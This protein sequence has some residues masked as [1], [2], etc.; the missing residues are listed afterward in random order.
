MI[1]SYDDLYQILQTAIDKYSQTEGAEEIVFI[2]NENGTCEMKNQQSGKKFVMMFARFG[3]EFKVGFA[4]YEPAP[5]GGT[6]TPEWIEDIF[7]HEF[8]ENFAE[9]LI[10][11]HLVGSDDSDW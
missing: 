1:E 10:T 7:N 6:G 11:E 5:Y 3:D 4:F 2:K 9:T 8:D